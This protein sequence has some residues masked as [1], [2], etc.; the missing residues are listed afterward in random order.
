MVAASPSLPVFYAYGWVWSVIIVVRF[1]CLCL[2]NLVPT[3]GLPLN[4][5]EYFVAVDIKR[6]VAFMVLWWDKCPTGADRLAVRVYN[7]LHSNNLRITIW[8][9]AVLWDIWPTDGPSNSLPVP[10]RHQ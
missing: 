5:S 1:T 7:S 3:I 4:E 2:L 9:R 8:G 6:I 10:V